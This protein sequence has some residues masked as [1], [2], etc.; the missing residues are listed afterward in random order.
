MFLGFLFLYTLGAAEVKFDFLKSSFFVVAVFQWPNRAVI[1]IKKN[2]PD[3]HPKPGWPL[4]GEV[5][6]LTFFKKN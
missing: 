1:R 6:F 4:R 2:L 3:P 5:Q